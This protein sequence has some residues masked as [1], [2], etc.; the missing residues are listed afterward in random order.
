MLARLALLHPRLGTLIPTPAPLKKVIARKGRES[1]VLIVFL[2]GIGDLAED[3]IRRGILED[4]HLNGV[5][6]DAI[7]IDAHY[8]YYAKKLIFERITA[9][10]IEWGR[11]NG[12]SRIWL[13]GIS[14]GGYGA[15]LYAA[16]HAGQVEGLILFA[17]YLGPNTLIE[18]IRE[19]GGLKRWDP[20]EVHASDHARYLWSW[21]KFQRGAPEPSLPIY[22][23]YGAQDKFAEANQLFSENIASNRV[24]LLQGGH[25]WATWKR[26]WHAL[27]PQWK[28]DLK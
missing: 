11:E 17:P 16:R 9:D 14:L 15:A 20:G 23:A 21:L 27:L 19:A 12:Y 8:G 25:N 26:L 5:M 13:A 2:P 3:F 1:G 28:R 10:V 4:M 7:A 18:E 6:V 24:V 22:L